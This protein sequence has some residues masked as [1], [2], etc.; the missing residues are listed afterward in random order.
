MRWWLA[1]A[2]V[3]I[4]MLTA[5]A[6]A[7][8]FSL[9]YESA[10]RDEAESIAIGRAVDAGSAIED[11]SEDGRL[12]RN[13]ADVIQR[14]AERRR[15]AVWVYTFSGG[16]V[17][18]HKSLGIDE[19][20]VPNRD[21]ALRAAL[22]DTAVGIAPRNYTYTDEATGATI[23]AQPL[24]DP[25]A[26]AMIAYAPRSEILSLTSIVR[27]NL[28]EAAIFA[29]G[30]SAAMGLLVAA[31]IAARLRRIAAGAAAIEAGDF[32][33]PV[34][35]SF[36]DELG[37]LAE[38]IDRMRL[39]LRDSFR[40]LR[41]DRDRLSRLLERLHEGVITVRDDLSIDYANPAAA[42]L[43]GVNDLEGGEDLPEP[44]EDF[45]LRAL[46]V[47]LFRPGA[48]V[49]QAARE[50]RRGSH[51][52]GRGN[53]GRAG[54]AQRRDRA[55]GHLRAGAPRARRARVR[56][57]R[58]AR[59][60]HAAGRHHERRRGAAG[61]RQ[62]LARGARPLPRPHRA[63]GGAPRAGWRAP[64][65]CSPAPRRARRCRASRP[66]ELRAAAAG[67]R[68]RPAPRGRRRRPGGLPARPDRARPARPRRAGRRE[69][70]RER[71]QAHEQR[72]DPDRGARQRRQRGLDRGRRQRHG[73]PARRARA[74]LRPLLPRRRAR[75]GRLRARAG[76]RAPGSCAR[77]AASSSSIRPRGR[78]HDRTRRAP[79]RTGRA[80]RSDAAAAGRRRRARHRS[81]RSR[82]RCER[83]GFDVDSEVDGEAALV[84]RP[85]A[86][87]RPARARRDDARALR[88][89]RLPHAARR[90]RRADHPAHGARRRGRP[91]ARARARRRRLRH[92][93]VLDGRAGE[94]RA[95]AAA[96]P[97][98]RPRRRPAPR[99]ASSAACVST[100]RATRSGWTARSCT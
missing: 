56:D 18:P 63:R 77:S 98:A 22:G 88:H 59:A 64:C 97:R 20:N 82:T 60:A 87:L 96:P 3:L 31:F 75:S 74:R 29:V 40:R 53:P 52:R 95:R 35:S 28:I 45:S 39:N 30:I 7:Q 91:R 1:L 41:S 94:P 57:Q 89:R 37:Q 67:R 78:R 42:R 92:E 26:Q 93:A 50:P 65:S 100:S 17:T 51:L 43:L 66:I 14:I 76:D 32:E 69:P 27:S 79:G 33:R 55:H 73:H 12:D 71:R 16:L 4:A 24:S 84:G 86:Q 81:T 46:A 83:E 13:P 47:G 85:R 34:S 8:L 25:D 90:E 11:A 58:R 6:T 54:R 15:I 21:E 44:W 10:L 61:R 23:I 68:G 99:C 38:S 36:R 48:R 19:R 80:R 5:F 72:R 70:G 2:F 62:G 9:R 49:A